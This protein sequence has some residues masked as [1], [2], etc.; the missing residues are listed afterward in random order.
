MRLAQGRDGVGAV[1][2]AGGYGTRMRPLSDRRPKHLLPV[3]DDSVIGHQLRRLCAVGV[4]DV[5]LA[6]AHLA[7]AFRPVLGE[8]EAYGVH[9]HYSREQTPLGTG[10]ALRMGLARLPDSCQT[11]IVLNGDLL[12]SHDLGEQLEAHRVLGG[13]AT[14]HARWVDDA[15]PFGYLHT[16]GTRVTKFEE[17]PAHAPSGLVNAGTY[18][19]KR[20]VERYFFE[21]ECSVE[22]EIFPEM[23]AAEESVNIHRDDA[24]FIDIGSPAA[25][26]E[27]NIDWARQR[28]QSSVILEPCPGVEVTESLI[29]RG[30]HIEAG[31]Q[32]VRS[33]VAPGT[34]IG[35][36]TSIENCIVADG[37][38]V[39]ARTH[40]VGKTLTQENSR[41]A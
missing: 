32:I 21:D 24:P 12:S 31:A 18:I 26:L 23:I 17:K 25:L 38:V 14:V 7:E 5:V 40:F 13:M 11:I 28:G 20:S 15:S 10:G 41:G 16:S 27:A 22:R 1:I 4:T 2:L 9:L 8:G 33:I 37:V 35:A 6:T 36:D 30:A 34:R 3:G 39:P 29:M 19:F